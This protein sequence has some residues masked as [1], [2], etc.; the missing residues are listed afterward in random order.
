MI[1]ALYFLD[2]NGVRF[3]IFC[4]GSRAKQALADLAENGLRAEESAGAP[5]IDDFANWDLDLDAVV[6]AAPA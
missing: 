5:R 2:P 6:E 1:L 4:D 3:E